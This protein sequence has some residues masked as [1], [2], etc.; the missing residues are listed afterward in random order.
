MANGVSRAYLNAY[1]AIDDVFDIED[2]TSYSITTLSSDA[3]ESENQ[4]E[5]T[6]YNEKVVTKKLARRYRESIVA[7]CVCHIR[8]LMY[9]RGVENTLANRMVVHR[10]AVA[11]LKN[12]KVRDRDLT[13]CS[14]QVV[15]LFFMKNKNDILNA[16]I[17]D[18]AVMRR[19][20][21][22][23][24]DASRGGWFSWFSAGRRPSV[25]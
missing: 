3:G 20:Q 19:Q 8:T 2:T 11:Y 18:C 9:A 23:Y 14:E 22:E 10:H 5:M 21:E 17:D 15:S 6:V 25:L 12:A 1:G 24:E 16:A 13:N 4:M 7:S